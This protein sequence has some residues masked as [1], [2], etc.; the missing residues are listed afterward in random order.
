MVPS[1]KHLKVMIIAGETS[2]DLYGSILMRE[3]QRH[4]PWPIQF[5]G[6]GGDAMLEAGQ[7]QHCHCD[8]TSVIGIWGV[9]IRFNFFRRLLN[10]TTAIL[11][12]WKPDFLLTIDY[13]GFN[14]RLAA[15]AHAMGIRTIHYVCPQVWVWNRRRI[16]SIA[17]DVDQLY[18]LFPFEPACFDPTP[19]RPTYLG[20]PLV[21][22]IANFL[23][24]TPTP[25]PWGS[26]HRIALL[27][28]S[29][30][31]EI[32]SL[33]PILMKTAQRLTEELGEC[34]FIIPASSRKSH[35][36][37]KACLAKST[38]RNIEVIN[39]GAREVLRQAA[40]AAIASGTATL[41]ATLIGCPSVLIYRT[42][43]FNYHLMRFLLRRLSY[44]GLANI[45]ANRSVM[46][47]LLQ[48]DLTPKK[49]AHL[50]HEYLT[51]DDLIDQLNRDYREVGDLLG[52][53]GALAKTAQHI[54]A[55]LEA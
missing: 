7:K 22:Q 37:I 32:T 46:P 33:M 21:D 38:S 4:S 39:G 9:I 51:N 44:V 24:Q 1:S 18:T 11:S 23:S 30:S 36:L 53:G 26:G 8:D 50:L 45:V 42:S 5:R 6:I 28:G 10:Q 15:R 34:S 54:L 40:A 13:P 29:R 52:S 3:L 43:W 27:P 49:L 14:L 47:E 17:R 12:D 16:H 31:H 35:T 48:N 55:S 41:E 20:H 2:G 19:L 25:L